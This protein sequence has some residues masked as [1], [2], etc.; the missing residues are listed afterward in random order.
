MFVIT[1]KNECNID[2]KKSIVER[3]KIRKIKK[4]KFEMMKNY[5][6]EIFESSCNF[7]TD[8]NNENECLNRNKDNQ[9]KFEKTK[10]FEYEIFESNCDFETEFDDYDE[11]LNRNKNEQIKFEKTKNFEC[12]I[13]RFNCD[14]ETESNDEKNFFLNVEFLNRNQDDK[15]NSTKKCFRQFDDYTIFEIENEFVETNSRI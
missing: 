8:L 3:E 5:E 1:T 6:C 14:F 7:E 2:F 15:K 9:T 11:C 10:N 13:F 4:V 12:E